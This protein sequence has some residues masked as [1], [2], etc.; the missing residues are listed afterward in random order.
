M[1]DLVK[2]NDLQNKLRYVHKSSESIEQHLRNSVHLKLLLQNEADE[3]G[4]LR[5]PVK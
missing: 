3:L 1:D 5:K 4:H 2:Q